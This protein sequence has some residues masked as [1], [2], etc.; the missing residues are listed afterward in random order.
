MAS[1]KKSSATQKFVFASAKGASVASSILSLQLERFEDV[2]ACAKAKEK[3]VELNI[4]SS[5]PSSVRASKYTAS[6]LAKLMQG[7]DE[8]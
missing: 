1:M 4:S 3:I 8:I 6:R 7:L 2:H 5:N